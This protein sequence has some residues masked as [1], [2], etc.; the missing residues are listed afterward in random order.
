MKPTITKTYEET[1]CFF[2]NWGNILTK[3]RLIIKDH[4]KDFFKYLNL[5]GKAY[6]ELIVRREDLKTKYNNESARIAAKKD[7]AVV[8]RSE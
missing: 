2:K 4:M 1:S 3:Q 5:E 7:P 6:S 8:L